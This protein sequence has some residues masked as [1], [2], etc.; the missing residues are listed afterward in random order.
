MLTTGE[1]CVGDERGTRGKQS[2]FIGGL[3]GVRV[4][5]GVTGGVQ[6]INSYCVIVGLRTWSGF[7]CV[8]CYKW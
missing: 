5:F 7:Q 6:S 1:M 2:V 4:G 3:E 8:H